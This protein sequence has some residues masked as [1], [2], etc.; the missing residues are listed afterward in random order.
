VDNGPATKKIIGHLISTGHSR[1][2]CLAGPKEYPYTME[3]VDGYLEA[4]ASAGIDW[5]VVEHSSYLSEEILLVIARMLKEHPD[6]DAL[7]VTA[8]GEFILDTIDALRSEKKDL[9]GFGM[10]VFDD[11]RFFDYLNL[12]ISTIRQ[13]LQDIGTRAASLLFELMD[14]KKPERTDWVLMTEMITR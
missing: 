5:S 14:G 8:G 2:A 7:Y 3:R 6:M 1:I 13:P 11:Y 9:T 10:A 4:L 12:S